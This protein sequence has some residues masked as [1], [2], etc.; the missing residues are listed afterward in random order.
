MICLARAKLVEVI[1]VAR[2]ELLSG[3]PGGVA[4]KM[5]SLPAYELV[6]VSG[7][8]HEA[9]LKLGISKSDLNP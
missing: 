6:V 8:L 9:G 3:L 7:K 1:M 5:P 4:L 2:N